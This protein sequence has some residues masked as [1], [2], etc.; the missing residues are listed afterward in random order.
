M[1]KNTKS[2]ASLLCRLFFKEQ[3]GTGHELPRTAFVVVVSFVK[4]LRVC[5]LCAEQDQS[6][7][8]GVHGGPPRSDDRLGLKGQIQQKECFR[9]V[10]HVLISTCIFLLLHIGL[11]VTR[12]CLKGDHLNVEL[13]Q[14]FSP[15]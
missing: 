4:Q 5:S 8:A 3:H 10:K 2:E 14:L 7:C 6:D 11:N 9:G 13:T 12:Y 15:K 1:T